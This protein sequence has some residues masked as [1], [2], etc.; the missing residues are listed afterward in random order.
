MRTMTT[1]ATVAS[2]AAIALLAAGCGKKD[3][4]ER[5]TST[6][7][8]AGA[9][10]P[11]SSNIA[12]AVADL[13]LGKHVDADKRITDETD[14]FKQRD[15]VYAS[16]ITNGA[17][18]GASLDAIWR[19]SDGQVVDSTRQMISPTGEAATA[20]FIMKPDGL[21]KGKYTVTVLLNGVEAKREEFEV[22][23]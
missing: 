23:D 15:T 10:A 19:F 2:V 3:A 13:K 8:A 14:N 1:R 6:D 12:L 20:F 7:T 18:P 5:A 16:V 22:D 9:V 11:P 17:A 21:P 4:D